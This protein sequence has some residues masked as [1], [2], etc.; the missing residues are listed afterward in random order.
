[1]V[2]R[3]TAVIVLPWGFA[4][5]LGRDTNA[6][7]TGVELVEL[8]NSIRTLAGLLDDRSDV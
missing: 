8:T 3:S 4:L 6:V 1:V 5:L 2:A 7:S